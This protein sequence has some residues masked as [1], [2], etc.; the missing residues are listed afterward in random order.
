MSSS[1]LP[2]TAGPETVAGKH[3]PA[4][5]HTPPHARY[6]KA[7]VQ[8]RPRA[9]RPA[10]QARPR[11]PRRLRPAGAVGAAASTGTTPTITELAAA[12]ET[13][14]PR[15][16]PRLDAGLLRRGT[17]QAAAAAHCLILT[18]AGHSALQ[19]ASTAV[20]CQA[21]TQASHDWDPGDRPSPGRPTDRFVNYLITITRITQ[22][23]PADRRPGLT[24]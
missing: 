16:S 1:P 19:T 21:I 18:Q 6:L 24:R 13:S 9:R 4:C 8:A 5:R 2:V 11:Y 15:A 14:Q 12:L 3:S 23:D 10:R 7:S 17:D 20:R 22:Q